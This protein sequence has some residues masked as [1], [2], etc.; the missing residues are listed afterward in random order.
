[1][2]RKK[3][4]R[5]Q[6]ISK[7]S[8]DIDDLM[9]KCFGF[10]TRKDIAADQVDVELLSTLERKLANLAYYRSEKE[11]RKKKMKLLIDSVFKFLERVSPPGFFFGI[12]PGDPGRIGFW[13][14]RLRFA[15]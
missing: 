7:G 15:P 5:S 6:V 12:H 4:Y 14:D 10:I 1:M 3:E 13:P 2:K 11:A 9:F 8:L